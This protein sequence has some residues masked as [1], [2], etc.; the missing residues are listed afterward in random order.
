M[1]LFVWDSEMTLGI[2]SLD[3][4]HRALIEQVNKLYDDIKLT[5]QG[6]ALRTQFWSLIQKLEE[7]FQT[8]ENLFEQTAFPDREHHQA[9][10][11][12]F[13]QEMGLVLRDCASK[14]EA[15]ASTEMLNYLVKWLSSHLIDED[16]HYVSHFHA[17]GVQ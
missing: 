3:A 8:E 15:E 9:E 16:K 1:P 7:H 2:P 17:H 12:R 10:H 11:S 4:Q 14:P 13:R 6:P 5:P